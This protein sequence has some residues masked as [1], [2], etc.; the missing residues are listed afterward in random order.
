MVSVVKYD[1][2]QPTVYEIADEYGIL[3]SKEEIR[4][5]IILYVYQSSFDGMLPSKL[6]SIY[7]THLKTKSV[8]DLVSPIDFSAF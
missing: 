2:Y 8:K 4:G 6:F 1:L 5:L 7:Q 3:L